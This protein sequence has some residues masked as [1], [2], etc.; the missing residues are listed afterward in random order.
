MQTETPSLVEDYG[1]EIIDMVKDIKG[2]IGRVVIGYEDIV[3]DLLIA[4]LSNGH[5]L[6]EGVPGIAKTTLAKTFTAILGMDCNRIQFT[7]DMLPQDIT[8]H[9]FYNQKTNDFEFRKGPIFSNLLLADEI[10]RTT[11]KTQSALLESMEERQATIEGTTFTLPHPFMVIATINPIEHEGVYQLPIAQA[12]RFMLKIN[13]GYI[14]KEKELELL[15]MK[16]NGSNIDDTP[17]RTFDLS[18]LKKAYKNTFADKSVVSYINDIISATR[19]SE[20]ITIGASP[21]ASEHMLYASKAK[22]CI[23]GRDYI[24]PDDVKAVAYDVLNHRLVLSPDIDPDEHSVGEIIFS[25]IESVK[26]P[27]EKR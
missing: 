12:D 6:L 5:V 3:E 23:S 4:L 19:G 22:A 26:V 16:A 14:K 13:M 9:F 21:R 8:G 20:L 18:I 17:L 7:P 2:E 11:P 27:L 24:I 25:I 15:I 10:N 1:Q